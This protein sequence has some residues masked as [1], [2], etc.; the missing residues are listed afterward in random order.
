MLSLINRNRPVDLAY[1]LVFQEGSHGVRR[2]LDLIGPF[3]SAQ[4]CTD[5][6]L[7]ERP[8][9][10]DGCN[11]DRSFFADLTKDVQEILGSQPRFTLEDWIG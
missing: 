11:R 3:G 4:Y 9:G 10:Y 1:I 5:S 7:T 6:L 8:G 2:L